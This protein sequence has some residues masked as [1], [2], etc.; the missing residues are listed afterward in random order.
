MPRRVINK[1]EV[2]RRL[3]E[4]L[5]VG[6]TRRTS[7]TYAGIDQNTFYRWIEK[8]REFRESVE[9]AEADAEVWHVTNIRKAAGDGTWTASA[10]W[11]ERRRHEEWKKREQLDLNSLPTSRLVELAGEVE[12]R[13][14]SAGDRA[15]LAE[16][17]E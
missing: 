6:N 1:A 13:I 17:G 9:K 15:A 4:A 10:W 16:S 14:E 3:L 8:D 11:L 2:T 12:R 5:K 7:Y